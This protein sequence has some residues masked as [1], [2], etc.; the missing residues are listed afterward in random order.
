M[1]AYLPYLPYII[2]VIVLSVTLPYLER[3]WDRIWRWAKP[4][5]YQIFW[6]ALFALVA[7]AIYFWIESASKSARPLSPKQ[8]ERIMA[9]E[10]DGYED[11]RDLPQL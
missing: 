4:I 9:G 7:I 10:Y 1:E 2:T 8:L 3:D 5:V 11:N 6:T